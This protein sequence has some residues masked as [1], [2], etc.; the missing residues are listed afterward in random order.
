MTDVYGTNENVV[1]NLSRDDLTKI[2]GIG[3]TTA[4]KLYN[5]KIVT[6]RQIAEM[7][8]ERLSETP[9]IGLATATKFIAAAKNRLESYQKEDVVSET[10]Q[11]QE[12]IKVKSGAIDF[13]NYEVEEVI[14]DEAQETSE[15]P[16][17][18]VEESFESSQTQEK[19][20]SDNYNN[21]KL[22]T[23]YSPASEPS[24]NSNNDIEVEVEVEELEPK[25][26]EI[27]DINSKPEEL[28][29]DTSLDFETQPEIE[30][31]YEYENEEEEEEEKTIKEP[32]IEPKKSE[33]GDSRENSIENDKVEPTPARSE[34]KD[35]A[36]SRD[37]TFESIVHQQISDTFKDAGCYEIP[38]SLES[39]KQ[40][41]T[42]LDYLGCK[43]AKA[44]DDLRILFLFPVKRFDREGTVLIDESKV[45]LKSHSSKTDLGAYYDIEQ[46]AKDLLQ[47]RDSMYQDIISDQ[48]ILRFFQK[49]LQITLSLEKGFGNKSVVF[50]SGTTQY[51]VFIEPILLCYNPPKSM[52]KSLVFPYQR[53]SNLH[54]VTK[55]DLA[56]LVA[57]LEKKYRMIEK[58]TKKTNS[59]KDY[60]QSE[61]KF[62]ASVKYASIPIFGY[63]AALMF[64]YFAGMYYLLRL[65]N[66]IG[67]ALIGIYIAVLLFF[68]FNFS[69]IKKRVTTQFKTP[70]YLQKLEFSEIDLLD[71]KEDLTDELLAQFGYE[72]L[73]KDV[74]FGVLEQSET[75]ALRQSVEEK[76]T[77]PIIQNLFETEHSK[78]ETVS[79]L[80]TKYNVKYSSFLDDP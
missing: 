1:V 20:F 65:F 62:H 71:F 19:W 41:T 9:G 73:G 4:E 34:S 18:D 61:E 2:K 35:F 8:P 22:T 15:E 3:S 53:S 48:N 55:A 13:E 28:V 78:P 72:C 46:V 54:A 45:E 49:Y 42:P 47:V 44:S 60:Q 7:T 14:V 63:S 64:L 77:E 56:P 11:I 32:P 24:K 38:S 36:Y 70:Y 69:R 10:A 23:S 39:L 79:N 27:N 76:R 75:N 16:H 57:F 66:T 37:K 80:T 12:V 26:E 68:Y 51:K 40:F 25:A 74:K 6:V 21:S 67:L 30:Q 59:V 50:L 33:I 5:A 29:I 52:E 58:R 31:V 17:N 43:V